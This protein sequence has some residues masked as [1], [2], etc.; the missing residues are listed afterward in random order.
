[1]HNKVFAAVALTLSATVSAAPSYIKELQDRANWR[2][3]ANI[4]LFP[5]GA[6]TS[7]PV[8]SKP[9]TGQDPLACVNFDEKL[10]GAHVLTD[11]YHG[12]TIYFFEGRDCQG[13][14]VTWTSKCILT[15][16]TRETI[17]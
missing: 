9:T 8:Y 5:D 6:C 16:S 15:G 11:S 7:K 14:S 3:N 1:M 13:N 10:Y 12:C 4:F 2:F 17:H